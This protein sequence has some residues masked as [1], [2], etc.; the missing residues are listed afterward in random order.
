M[1]RRWRAKVW[2]PK[3]DQHA[4]YVVKN[5][6]GCMLVSAPNAPEPL[7]RKELPSAAW[8]HLA[9]D[10]LGPLPSGHNLFVI[11]DYYSRFVEIEIMKKID[12][13]ETIKRLQ[14]IFVRF[15]LPISI[16]ADNGRQLISDE[17]RTYC[18]INNIELISTIPY[19]PQQ[20]GEIERQ[21]PSI[22]KRL[23]Y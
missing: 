12:S 13:T 6:R 17:F 1:K 8:Q 20:N 9:I 15:G 3:I 23:I 16:T 21:N 4:E 2:W 18:T 5:C 19:W 14:S 11:V 10:F 7:R 22:L